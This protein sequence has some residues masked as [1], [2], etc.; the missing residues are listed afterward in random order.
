MSI[1]ETYVVSRAESMLELDRRRTY[2]SRLVRE[3]HRAFII[4]GDAAVRSTASAA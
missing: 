3:H 1:N 2:Q 4:T